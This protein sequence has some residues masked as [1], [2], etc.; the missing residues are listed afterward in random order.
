VV[1][2]PAEEAVVSLLHNVL[3]CSEAHPVSYMISTDLFPGV[4]AAWIGVNSPL[5]NVEVKYVE[6]FLH[7]PYY[8]KWRLIKHQTNFNFYFGSFFVSNIL[9]NEYKYFIDTTINI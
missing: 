4:K 1:Q 9:N 2:L 6:L 3:T 5:S 7:T 8:F